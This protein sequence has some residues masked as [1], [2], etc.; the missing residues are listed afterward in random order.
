[1]N[2][3]EEELQKRQS[4][5]PFEDEL[6]ARG[7][8]QQP[9]DTYSSSIFPV[10]RDYSKPPFE[11][12]LK[13]DSD[14]GLV[15]MVKRAFLL[16]GEVM[17]G[18][19]DPL[20]EE[21]IGRAAEMGMVFSPMTPSM[22]NSGALA[23]SVP[24][25]GKVKPKVPTAEE[26]KAAAAPVYQQLDKAGTEFS[27]KSVDDLSAAIQNELLQKRAIGAEDAP[28][29]FTT[30]RNLQNAPEGATVPYATG[31]NTARK[32]LSRRSAKPDLN[33]PGDPAASAYAARRI[34]Q[35][36]EDDAGQGV[37]AGPSVPA[38]LLKKANRDYAA[39]KRSEV[40]T[41]KID[42]AEL[43][44]AAA[45]SGKNLGNSIRQRVAGL[46]TNKSSAK[47]R[48]G[49]TQGELRA[50]EKV[51]EGSTAANATRTAGNFLGGGGGLGAMLTS[52]VGG[53]A[54]AM[55]GGP[56]GAVVGA[57]LPFLSGKALKAISNALT[58]GALKK[59]DKT[60]RMRSPLYEDLLAAAPQ[61]QISLDAKQALAKAALIEALMRQRETTQ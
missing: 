8:Q 45:N 43:A 56:A 30:L 16:P 4:G 17:R 49:F 36:F 33:N 15:G 48:F 44:A 50:L 14:A 5:N 9:G 24:L 35:Y 54:G 19:V 23:G 59:A 41:G 26:L 29:T 57:G 7:G 3:F 53:G 46:L 20:S 51:V 11:G 39:A 31:L 47:D 1:M 27:A 42:E 60:T 2:P 40:L 22:R 10:T 38:D 37:V 58:K 21:G 28:R 13:F 32:Q 6:S 25:P 55:A 61:R 12:G 52:S 18:E 34:M